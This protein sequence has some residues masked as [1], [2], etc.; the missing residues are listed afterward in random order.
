VQQVAVWN[1]LEVFDDHR[2]WRP[3][4][5]QDRPCLYWYLT[6]DDQP[7][8]ARLAD[9]AGG[10]LGGLPAI[11]AVPR[12]WL[13]LTLCDIGFRDEVEPERLEELTRRVADGL[14]LWAPLDLTLGPVALFPDAV[15]LA[16]G[17]WGPLLE[18]RHTV[19]G[20]M[21]SVGLAP[22][23]HPASEFWPHVTLGYLNRRSDKKS[24]LDALGDG[25]AT[26]TIRVDRVTLAAVSRREGHYQWDPDAILTLGGCDRRQVEGTGEPSSTG[27][28]STP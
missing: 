14:R 5:T 21:E 28:E 27:S 22:Q 3:D 17:P 2:L 13:H 16:A 26:G 25:E 23:H 6:F 20:A 7:A 12:R 19:V 4:W 8:V 24:V 11:D 10:R 15:T 1:E 9:R 18:L